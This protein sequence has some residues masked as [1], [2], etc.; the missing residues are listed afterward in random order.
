MEASGEDKNGLLSSDVNA[1]NWKEITLFSYLDRFVD[2][3][4]AH[5]G[6]NKAT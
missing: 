2:A 6:L 3:K 1:V 4:D 5:E